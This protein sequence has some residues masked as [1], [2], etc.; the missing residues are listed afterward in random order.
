MFRLLNGTTLTATKKTFAVGGTSRDSIGNLF[1]VG[2][3]CVVDLIRLRMMCLDSTVTVSNGTV[4]A[5]E[6]MDFAYREANVN[7][8]SSGNTLRLEGDRPVVSCGGTVK[9]QQSAVLAVAL[10]KDKF[11]KGHV[12]I[13]V[14]D[15]TFDGTSRIRVEGDEFFAKTGGTVVLAEVTG[16]ITLPAAAITASLADMPAGCRLYVSGK[17]LVFHAPGMKGFCISIR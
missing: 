17:K 4:Q 3:G 15:L 9:F 10:P 6:S 14:K 8:F 13:R 5:S 16:S 1:Y 11:A 7:D 12:P 2:D